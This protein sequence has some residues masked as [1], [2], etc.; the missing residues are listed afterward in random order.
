[1]KSFYNSFILKS[2]KSIGLS[3]PLFLM[4]ISFST[5][6]ATE[7]PISENPSTSAVVMDCDYTLDLFDSFGDG[8]NGSILTVTVGGVSTDYTIDDGVGANF[9][10]TF[11]QNEFIQ[12]SYS[13]GAFQGEVSYSILD[14][15]GNEIFSDGPNPA[16]GDVFSFFACP[17]CPGPTDVSIDDVA[18]LTADISW[19]ASD[20]IGSY[21]VEYGLS[22]FT[23]GMGTG[24]LIP[25]P[26]TSATLTGLAE[27]SN[28]D[29]YISTACMNGDTSAYLGPFSFQTIY[30]IDVG[31]SAVLSPATGCGLGT[32]VIEVTLT[33]YGAL[34]QSLI[35][36]FYSVNGI[37]V[38]INVP[39][40]GFY[41]GV[42]SQDSSTTIEF[43]AM[44]DFS[45]PG[46]YTIAS[47]TEHAGDSQTSNDTSYLE[48]S[49]IPIISELPY[50]IDFEVWDGGWGIGEESENSTWEFGTP[51]ATLIT[52][53]A[54]GINA[55]VTNLTDDYNNNELSYLVSPCI[56]FSGITE[57]PN[58]SFSINFDTELNWD[59]IW[60]EGSP[61]GG[62]TWVKIGTM[63][64][65]LN[66]YNFENNNTGL[67]EVWAGN[68]GGWIK[69]EHEL[70]GFEGQDDI[71]FRFAFDSDG[72]ATFEGVAID[73][74]LISIPL[75]N[76][77]AALNVEHSGDPECGSTLDNV[78][79]EIRNSG[80]APQTDI[81]VSYTVNAGLPITEEIIDL[82]ILPGDS[83]IHTFATSFNSQSFETEFNIV[84]WV[85]SSLEENFFNDTTRLS[86]TTVDPQALPLVEDFEEGT[87]PNGW[88]TDGGLGNGHNLPSFALFRNLFITGSTY[89][90][91]TPNLG[92]I[93]PGDSLTFDYRYTDWPQ[94][95]EGITLGANDNLQ[96]QISTDCGSE[97]S[98]FSVQT[99][100][101]T[102]H[103]VSADFANV[104]VD[105]DAYAG[106]V[107]RIRFLATHGSGDYWID[108]DNINIIGCPDEFG[109]DP[110]VSGETAS[111]EMDGSIFINPTQGTGPYSFAWSNGDM[112]NTISGLETGIYTVS[113]TDA[114][115]CSGDLDVEIVTCPANLGVDIN[116]FPETNDNAFDGKI[117]L[118]PTGGSGPYTYFWTTGETTNI[119]SN[120]TAGVYTV[121]VT[122]ANGCSEDLE[123]TVDV[124]VG[125]EELEKNTAISLFPNPTTGNSSLQVN[126]SEASNVNYTIF[127]AVGKL[128]FTSN[129]QNTT[130]ANFDINLN[131]YPEGMYFIRVSVGEAIATKKLIINR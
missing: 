39:L 103:T 107:I 5:L 95:T 31:V 114:L 37:P 21:I 11:T 82:T 15:D 33:N 77:L 29:F 106:E 121:R 93:N 52:E 102:N 68:S 75:Q 120:V 49:S 60:L 127:N 14:P 25:T 17:T 63:G 13:P 6:N 10:V 130:Q 110:V 86:F 131:G 98:Y 41:T 47:W 16:V 27:N 70:I 34:P 26:A 97:G 116:I 30:L 57:T 83:Y 84:A 115:G 54:S 62:N 28:Y 112:G 74:I 40:D 91:T 3:L 53:A 71:L 51:N 64:S 109:V 45:Q 111:G 123:I 58:I 92:P 7:L 61:D 76:D 128:I 43:E 20:S 94:G 90:T 9:N 126:M 18:A 87:I 65:G 8:W 85:S 42:L 66:W 46:P 101:N 32:D 69:A 117:T 72:S 79:L 80:L 36:F 55:W 19:T 4:F 122:D 78:V 35:S 12:L 125:F 22:G 104:T 50:F 89:T 56:D 73:D 1:M 124:G 113:I 118:S 67:G 96:I 81:V 88:E 44:F 38:N 129:S 23:P 2:L 108:L 48:I 105:L 24:T 119:L 59:G 100:D 99:I